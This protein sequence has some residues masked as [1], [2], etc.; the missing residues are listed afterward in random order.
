MKAI[1]ASNVR[2]S[3]L[4][5]LALDKFLAFTPS[6]EPLSVLLPKAITLLA[7]FKA[8]EVVFNIEVSGAII[9][10]KPLMK[11]Q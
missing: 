7:E 9:L 3:V 10:L 1:W 11:H 4:K 5:K 6:S 2:K 8:T